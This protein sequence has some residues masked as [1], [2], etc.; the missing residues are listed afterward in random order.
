[1][2]DSKKK[3]GEWKI[4][5][6]FQ[7]LFKSRDMYSKSNNIEIMMGVGGGGWGVILMK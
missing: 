7:K 1:M 2:T 3:R 6:F 5:Y 4:Q